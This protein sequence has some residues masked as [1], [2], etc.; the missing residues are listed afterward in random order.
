MGVELSIRATRKKIR[1]SIRALNSLPKLSPTSSINSSLFPALTFIKVV[2]LPVVAVSGH[3]LLH[4][5]LENAAEP[6][7]FAHV[8]HEL[9]GHWRG[10]DPRGHLA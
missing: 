8:A 5:A 9:D 7:G 1:F 3:V 2:I 4:I 10:L 6:I